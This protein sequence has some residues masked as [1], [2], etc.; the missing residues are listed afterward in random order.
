MANIT[1]PSIDEFDELITK[2]RKIGKQ[3]GLKKS[4]SKKPL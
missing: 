3:A 2:A 1:P 4:I